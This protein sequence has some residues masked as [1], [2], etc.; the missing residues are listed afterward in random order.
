MKNSSDYALPRREDSTN[1]PNTASIE[2]K[3]NG[4]LLLGCDNLNVQAK[5][6]NLSDYVTLEGTGDKTYLHTQSSPS[7]TWE[8]AHN[9]NKHPAVSVIDS[10]GTEVQGEVIYNSINKI[11]IKFS[12]AFSGKATLN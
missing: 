9:L 10:A 12:A 2:V 8:I 3:T 5:N 11:T 1:P 7:D 6:S 4:E